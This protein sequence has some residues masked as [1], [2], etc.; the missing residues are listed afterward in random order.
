[1]LSILA[2]AQNVDYT[3]TYDNPE[4]RPVWILNADVLDMDL[5][6]DNLDGLALN[7]GV[8]GSVEPVSRIGIDYRIRRSWLV[9]ARIGGDAPPQF[10]LELGGYF[11]LSK[12]VK[13]KKTKIVLKS[14][15]T[16]NKNTGK[17]GTLTTYITIPAKRQNEFMVRG[18]FYHQSGPYSKESPALGDMPEITAG[19]GAFAQINSNGVYTGLAIRN[20]KNVFI[21]DP[22]YGKSFNSIANVYFLDALFLSNSFN[23]FGFNTD[24]TDEVKTARPPVLPIGFRIGYTGYQIEKKK[25]T[26]KKFGMSQT[27]EIGYRPYQGFYTGVSLSITFVKM[28]KK[29]N[30]N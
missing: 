2:S 7:L 26:G 18:G 22:V 24:I 11:V 23:D 10:K 19:Q 1:M 29:A 16:Y 9:L 13:T 14:E 25:Y 20:I 27:Y 15:S 6:L 5:Y 28:I 17:D 8:W 12:T 21:K 3:T 4:I 30:E